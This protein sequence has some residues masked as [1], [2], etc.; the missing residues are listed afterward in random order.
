MGPVFAEEFGGWHGVRRYV[1]GERQNGQ[2]ERD[3]SEQGRERGKRAPGSAR[4]YTIGTR[5]TTGVQGVV[6]AQFS[7][8]RR[9]GVL[10]GCE[11]GTRSSEPGA[12]GP[13]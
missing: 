1:L 9:G 3:A 11:R 6:A 2:D 4:D 12:K 7:W 5:F 13:A 8:Q 10:N